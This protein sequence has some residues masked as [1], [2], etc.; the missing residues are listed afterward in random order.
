MTFVCCTGSGA[1]SVRVHVSQ[2]RESGRGVR[3][4]CAPYACL[5]EG[6]A[7]VSSAWFRAWAHALAYQQAKLGDEEQG[8]ANGI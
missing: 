6:T 7:L 3:D 2:L 8:K 1:I 5:P 4:N